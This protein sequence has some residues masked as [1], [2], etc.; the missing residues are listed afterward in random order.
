MRQASG[1]GVV[2]A[3]C[4]L[5]LAP[6]AVASNS[7]LYLDPSGDPP[8]TAPDLASVQV[9]N[10]DAGTVV[11]RLSIPNRVTLA[12][13]DLVAVLVDADGKSGTGCAR[14]TFGAEYALDVLANR[15]V[16]GRCRRGQW[17]FTRPPAS[18]AGTFGHSTLTL[19]VNRRDLGGTS[20]FRF[21]IGSAATSGAEPDYDF[22]PE[23]GAAPWSYQ[24]IAPPGAAKQPPRHR[25]RA[26]RARRHP[27]LPH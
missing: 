3:A 5:L 12:E 4:L 11:F 26:L 19:Q 17:D 23:V 16:F 22:A 10:D 15:Y 14:G 6:G 13:S 27:S 24:I 2:V 9:S 18:F 7:T 21:R 25:G 20:A 8:T 1:F